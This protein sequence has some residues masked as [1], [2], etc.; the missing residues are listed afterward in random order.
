MY[1][2]RSDFDEVCTNFV[3]FAINILIMAVMWSHW[4]HS[5][6]VNKFLVYNYV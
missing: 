6:E 1:K 5:K 3:W 4:T 2:N